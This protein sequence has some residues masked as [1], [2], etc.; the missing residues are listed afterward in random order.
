MEK[1]SSKETRPTAK[2][3]L[4]DNQPATDNVEPSNKPPTR[5]QSAE[6]GI[7]VNQEPPTGN[8]SGIEPNQ[9]IPEVETQANNPLGKDAD[10]DPGSSSSVKA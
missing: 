7:G 8:Q 5:N 3:H 4:S 9:E 10:N 6:A 1:G 2:D